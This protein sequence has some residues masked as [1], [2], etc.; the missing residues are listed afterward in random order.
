MAA[1]GR[2]GGRGR[3]PGSWRERTGDVLGLLGSLGM[4]NDTVGPFSFN[5][6][7]PIIVIFYRYIHTI[8][9]PLFHHREYICIVCLI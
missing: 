3:R 5:L 6:A 2:E 9:T 1:E 8:Y 4:V 7:M